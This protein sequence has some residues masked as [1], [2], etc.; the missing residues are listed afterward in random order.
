VIT[1][2]DRS[3]IRMMFHFVLELNFLPYVLRHRVISAGIQGM[4]ARDALD[5]H[6]YAFYQTIFDD[7]FLGIMRA[8]W[9]KTA[10]RR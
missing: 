10:G 2:T 5:A 7:S 3:V 8:T 1:I 9:H 6:A 4:T